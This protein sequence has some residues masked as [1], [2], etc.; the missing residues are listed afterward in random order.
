MAKK[1]HITPLGDRVLIRPLTEEELGTASV[2]GIIIPDS[3]HKEKSG[4]GEVVALGT[5]TINE[6][7][8][9]NMFDVA[10]GDRVMFSKYSYDEVKYEN[11][12]YYIVSSSNILAIIK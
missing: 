9:K 4:Q 8:E 2:F 7:G 10:V 3:V 1:I 11:N 12:E 5:G 6:K